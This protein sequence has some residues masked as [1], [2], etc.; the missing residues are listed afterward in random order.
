M[1]GVSPDFVVTGEGWDWSGGCSVRRFRSCDGG[2]VVVDGVPTGSVAAT[3]VE[4]GTRLLGGVCRC[5][6]CRRMVWSGG[7]SV[8]RLCAW[9][10]VGLSGG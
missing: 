4:Q 9:Q 8:C 10:G 6:A 1:A 3:G 7:W 5:R 2:G